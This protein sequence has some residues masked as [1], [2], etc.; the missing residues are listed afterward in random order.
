[1]KV[2]PYLAFSGNCQEAINFYADCFNAEVT[3]KI[4]YEHAKMDIPESYR[5]K[6]QHA[7]IKGNGVH[8]LAYDASPDTPLNSGN[9]IHMSI[10]LNDTEKAKALFIELSKGGQVNHPFNEERWG[11]LYRRCTDKFGIHWMIN[12]SL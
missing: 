8:I 9:K 4:T 11:A 12:C 5:N 3:N 6:I 7:E 2:R 10:D 1:M